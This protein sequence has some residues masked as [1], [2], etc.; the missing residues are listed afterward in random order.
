MNQW[1]TKLYQQNYLY[2]KKLAYRITQ[3]PCIADDLTQE[4][5]IKLIERVSMLQSL[6]AEK[7]TYYLSSTI[8]NISLNYVKRRSNRLKR[9]YSGALENLTEN[10]ADENVSIENSYLL[11]EN[12]HQLRQAI[13]QL[14]G[15][16]QA[17]LHLK[18]IQELSD[19][20]IAAKLKIS[21]KNIRS[22]LTR[23]RRRAYKLYTHYCD[24]ESQNQL[25]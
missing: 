8:R 11:H 22:Y 20:E 16:D 15:R 21:E 18:Y 9:I 25:F 17:L 4:A 13:C 12:C 14:S 7:R 10:I 2:M 24:L 6:D 1:I 23:A 3:D 19:K 5:F